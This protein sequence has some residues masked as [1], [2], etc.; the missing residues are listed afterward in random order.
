MRSI[1][2]III[3]N[4]KNFYRDKLRF[5]SNIL[6]GVLF[7]FIFSFVM[8]S[9][10]IGMA[11][12]INYLISGIIIMSVFQTALNNCMNIIEDIASGFMREI[13]V[14]PISRWQ[15]SIGQILSA[16]A[17]ALLQG[18]IMVI[19][20]LFM[21]L[22]IDA[23]HFIEM[24]GVMILVGIAFSSIGLYLATVAK[25]STTFQVLVFIF[26]M[27]LT[28]LSGAYIPTTAMPHFLLPLVYINPLTYTTSLFRYI[29]LKM[30]GLSAA[31]LIEAGVAFDIQGVVIMP[32]FGLA[33]I[34]V[35]GVLFL[36]LCVSR[37]NKADFSAVRV[38]EHHH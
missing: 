35:V 16:S 12:P 4:L 32:S 19:I 5:F 26:V 13:L 8:K 11:N 10:A 30:E 33:M 7:L 2:A 38:F 15:I 17:I 23:L 34:A 22:Q 29:S 28:F 14:A 25:N 24:I 9:A 37:F 3:R 1:T 6:M 31:Q 20:G 36:A 27:P 18:I 21:G